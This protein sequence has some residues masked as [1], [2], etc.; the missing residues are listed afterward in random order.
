MFQGCRFPLFWES[1]CVVSHVDGK[2]LI[3]HNS[4]CNYIFII[5]ALLI[6]SFRLFVVENQFMIWIYFC[7]ER[8][9]PII[10]VF[11]LANFLHCVFPSI[12]IFIYFFFKVILQIFEYIHISINTNHWGWNSN[13]AF[14]VHTSKQ[15][16]QHVAYSCNALS[17]NNTSLRYASRSC[18]IYYL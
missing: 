18:V 5:T 15:H 17:I 9:I 4:Y 13:H 16:K 12:S 8:A 1:S 7:Y 3:L 6:Y 14:A 11:I 10:N 2:W